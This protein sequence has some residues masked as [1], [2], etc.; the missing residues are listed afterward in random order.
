MKRQQIFRQQ[1]WLIATL[2]RHGRLTLQ[3]LSEKWES[4][5][6]ADSMPLSR[7]TFNRHRDAVFDMLG[8]II[9]CDV[10]DGY[11]YYIANPS[12]L[13]DDTLEHWLLSTLTVNTSLADSVSVKE[14]IVLENVPAGE[15]Y[16]PLLITA[17]RQNRRVRLTYRRF[18]M[19]PTE[20]TVAPYML[21]LFHRRWYLLAFTGRHY[22]IYSLDR[23]EA[24]AL[25]E[26]TFEMPDDF[27]P[28]QYF[29]EYFG[30]LTDDT[31]LQHVVIRCWGNVPA[32]LRTLPLHHSQREIGSGFIES[33]EITSESREAQSGEIKGGEN[34]SAEAQNAEAKSGEIKGGENQSGE[35]KSAEAQ[36]A[37]AKSAEAQSGEAKSGEAKGRAY[38]DFAYAIRPT[39]DFI[40]ELISYED[41]IEVLQPESLR[42]QMRQILEKMLRKYEDERAHPGLGESARA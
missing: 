17:I 16:L 33:G 20:K 1:I 27:S 26:S 41:T 10:K 30:V 5:E 14:R 15:E 12:L 35:A 36:S 7:T 24:L 28:H 13:N 23:F 18:G 38:T 21:K 42:Q 25:D 3:E 11:R 39:A 8:V 9:E 22:P 31:A 2:M 4:D 19:T 40:K 29:S 34:Q 6:M 32:Y 37:E